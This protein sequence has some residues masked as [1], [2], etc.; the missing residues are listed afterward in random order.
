ME[1]LSG[2]GWIDYNPVRPDIKKAR[3]A[4]DWWIVLNVPGDICKY[5]TW[6]MQ[7]EK[8]IS[9]QLPVWKPHITVLNGRIPVAEKYQDA[10]KKHQG[11]KIYFEYSPVISNNWKFWWLQVRSNR[12]QEI[13]QEL[14]FD[15]NLDIHLT[16]GR[17]FE[18][19][20]NLETI[21]HGL[22]LQ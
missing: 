15:T 17:E 22:Q 14:G 5:Y 1:W 20:P 13:R 8:G 12:I 10:W 6:W 7:Q 9:L 18:I 21:Q 3:R 11:E 2:F 16:I 19:E 4:D